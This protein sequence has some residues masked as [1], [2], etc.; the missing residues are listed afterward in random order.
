[1]YPDLQQITGGHWLLTPPSPAPSGKDNTGGH[2]VTGIQDD[3]REVGNGDLFIAITGTLADGHR[4]LEDA[5]LKGAAAVC[6]EPNKIT[7]EQRRFLERHRIPTLA[8]DSS[9]HAFHAIARQHRQNCDQCTVIAIT[10]SNGKTSVKQMLAAVLETAAPGQVLTSSGNTNNQFGVPRNL[11]RNNPDKH[12]F[13]IIEAGTNHPGEIAILANMIE[14]DI[15]VITNI[16][17]AHLEA[18][19]NIE[20]VAREKRDLMTTLPLNG[21]AILPNKGRAV[22]LLSEKVPKAQITTF[23]SDL[24]ADVSARYLSKKGHSWCT[25]LVWGKN[26]EKQLLS[27]HYPGS[28][29]ALNAAAVG[30]VADFL[31][32]PPTTVIEGLKK[33][34]MPAMRLET[35]RHCG[36]I[37]VND[38]YNANPDSMRAGITAFREMTEA[39]KSDHK[40][41]PFLVLGDMNE[42]GS[43]SVREHVDLLRWVNLK[44]P[45]TR[46]LTVGKTMQQAAESLSV[47]NV[48]NVEAAAEQLRQQLKTGD[49][50]FLKASRTVNL[51]KLLDYEYSTA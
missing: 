43:C 33:T 17:K 1:S 23:G 3:S 29:H 30:A 46:L 38:A 11:L 32:I 50:V 28:H 22:E 42:L 31:D 34:E 36:V 12:R 18:F 40:G 44:F 39:E 16:G 9:L 21:R 10:G 13:A 48:P 8:V 15:A 49:E 7:P 20:A 2:G 14:P 24:S 19:E 41:R 47:E 45:N 26:R 4:F 5:V 27:W 25:E 6:I 35:I 51:E 37:W